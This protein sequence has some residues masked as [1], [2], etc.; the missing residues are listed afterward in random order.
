MDNKIYCPACNKQVGYNK[1]GFLN[2]HFSSNT[3][4]RDTKGDGA[5]CS[6]S[7]LHWEVARASVSAHLSVGTVVR[8]GHENGMLAVIHRQTKE[9]TALHYGGDTV[10]DTVRTTALFPADVSKGTTNGWARSCGLYAA[11]FDPREV[12]KARATLEEQG[13]GTIYMNGE[14]W[15]RPYGDVYLEHV[16][17]IDSEGWVSIYQESAFTRV[18][19]FVAL[20]QALN[21][22]QVEKLRTNVSLIEDMIEDG[23]IDRAL[24]LIEDMLNP[25][26]PNHGLPDNARGKHLRGKLRALR[27]HLN[28]LPRPEAKPEAE[29]FAPEWILSMIDYHLEQGDSARTE[30]IIHEALIPI[31]GEEKA[32]QMIFGRSAPEIG[33]GALNE[34]DIE[35]EGEDSLDEAPAPLPPGYALERIIE[36]MTPLGK[37]KL[38]QLADEA[39]ADLAKS[40]LFGPDTRVTLTEKGRRAVQENESEDIRLWSAL[41]RSPS[42]LVI[43]EAIDYA[44]GLEDVDLEV[45]QDG[46]YVDDRR[47]HY[48][49]TRWLRVEQGTWAIG[50]HTDYYPEIS[51]IYREDEAPTDGNFICERTVQGWGAYSLAGDIYMTYGASPSPQEAVHLADLNMI[52]KRWVEDG[53]PAPYLGVKQCWVMASLNEDGELETAIIPL[54]VTGDKDEALDLADLPDPVICSTALHLVEPANGY[55]LAFTSAQGASNYLMNVVEAESTFH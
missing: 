6:G 50:H 27:D 29:R 15:L 30:E 49:Y 10:G 12:V 31:H 47:R 25:I 11:W 45:N 20:C 22:E 36:A 33:N 5:R 4:Y 54:D 2:T 46:A 9:G 8:V 18:E 42:P 7:G 35:E 17:T 16:A 26:D 48:H 13:A 43:R 40:P 19:I 44:N 3:L 38:L 21:G 34:D 14:V 53:R 41:K 52:T 55:Y 51:T 24:G 28:S 32:Y 1:E 39:L 23:E 37:G